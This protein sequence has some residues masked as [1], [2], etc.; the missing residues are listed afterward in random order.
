MERKKSPWDI[1][2]QLLR[3]A[4]EYRRMQAYKPFT[5]M[6]LLNRANEIGCGYADNFASHGIDIDRDRY[7]K[8]PRS[9]Y[10]Q[11]KED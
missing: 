9:I 7:T 10:A 5:A 6:L 2:L 3:I 1:H 11:R 8:F 4:G